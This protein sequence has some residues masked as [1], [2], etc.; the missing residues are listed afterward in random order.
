MPFNNTKA[1]TPSDP[2]GSSVRGGRV[3]GGGLGLHMH[4]VMRLAP[5]RHPATLQTAPILGL[6]SSCHLHYEA[7]IRR[8][9]APSSA[10]SIM[11]DL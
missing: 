5:D 8:L 11:H 7:P 2:A 9:P 4:P 6:R 1:Q 3:G 10:S